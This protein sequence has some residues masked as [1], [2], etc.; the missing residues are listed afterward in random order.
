MSKKTF[1]QIWPMLAA[2][3]PK[4]GATLSRQEL[5]NLMFQCFLI[6]YDAA[7]GERYEAHKR[8]VPVALPSPKDDQPRIAGRFHGCDK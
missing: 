3:A 6:G 1:D 4:E 5:Q 2:Y 8:A 7:I